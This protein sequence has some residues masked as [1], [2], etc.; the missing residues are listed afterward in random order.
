MGTTK[1]PFSLG[2]CFKEG[3]GEPKG[4]HVIY[5]TKISIRSYV[6]GVGGR[7][8]EEQKRI[9]TQ[10][11]QEICLHLLLFILYFLHLLEGKGQ[12]HKIDGGDQGET[13]GKVGV[14]CIPS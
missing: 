3:E 2:R 5:C 4:C 8:H 11:I 1:S 13:K 14:S 12:P 7:K 6:F 9:K 10:L